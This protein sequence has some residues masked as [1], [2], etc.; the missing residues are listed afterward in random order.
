MS[1][2][3]SA[4][5]IFEMAEEIERNG[6]KF[7]RKTAENVADPSSK[8]LLLEFASMEDEH[9]KTFSAMK[10][11]LSGKAK[12]SPTFDPN[13][14]ASLYL[15]ALAD[16][17]VFFKK[18]VDTKSLEGIFKAALLAEKDSIVFYTGMNDLIPE[19][20]GKDKLAAIIKEEMTH[21]RLLSDKL[22]ALKKKSSK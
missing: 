22:L 4:H 2:L 7:Y 17:R 20:L 21:I 10:S 16:T 12:E 14:E 8:K 18:D 15:A 6:A 5:E 9:L 13:N 19:A 11:A 1:L 3:F